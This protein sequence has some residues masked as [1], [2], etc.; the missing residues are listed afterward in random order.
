VNHWLSN[1]DPGVY[2]QVNSRAEL[3]KRLRDCIAQRGRMPNVIAVDFSARGDLVGTVKAVNAELLVEYRQLR[4]IKHPPSTGPTTTT[5]AP[6][7][8]SE[9]AGPLLPPLHQA[10]PIT[11]LTGGDPAALCAALPAANRATTAYALATYVAPPGGRALPDFAY[12]PIVARDLGTAYAVA[13]QELVRQGAAAI[14]RARAAVD[15]LR[16]LGL[17]QAAID[18]LAAK[19]ETELTSTEDRDPAV[20]QEAV[21]DEVRARVGAD[22]VNA[23]AAAFADSNPEPPGLFDLGDV[24]DQVAQTYGYGCAV[25]PAATN[26]PGQ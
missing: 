19:A 21:L 13:P 9:A 8:G 25:A 22:K 2:N 24:S 3:T 7:P 10:T 18:E 1:H 16:G 26:P 12:G 6:P 14:A 5:T 4:G 11:T 17:D 15:A 23:A 20:V